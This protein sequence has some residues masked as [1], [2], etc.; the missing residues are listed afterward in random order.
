MWLVATA[1]LAL[2][3]LPLQSSVNKLAVSLKGM[4]WRAFYWG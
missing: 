3:G 1:D 4:R 2:V